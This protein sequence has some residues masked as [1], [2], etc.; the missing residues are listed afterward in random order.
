MASRTSKT[1]T[2]K[3]NLEVKLSDPVT[4]NNFANYLLSMTGKDITFDF[5]MNSMGNFDG[6]VIANPYDLLIVPKNTFAYKTA[7]GKSATNKNEFTTTVGLYIFNLLLSSVD[8]T[9]IVGYIN[10]NINGKSY[11]AIDQQMFYAIIEDRINIQ[12]YKEWQMI[13][14][15][16]MPLQ[17]ILSTCHTEKML[18][19]GKAI[20]KRKAELIK[21]NQEA[22]DAGDPKVIEDIEKELLELAKEYIGDDPGLDSLN[23]GAGASFGNQFKNMYIIKGA[24]ANPDPN[25]QKKYTIITSSFI[26]GI[27]SDEYTVLGQS[28]VN[29]SYSR[30][31][32]TSVGGY[33]EKL[34]IN[35][36]QHVKLDPVGSDCGTKRFIIIELTE[37]NL[38]D[39]IYSY[40]I[41]NDGGLELITSQNYKKF[42]G[43]KTKIRFSS[44]C[45]S[46][47][48]ICNICAGKLIYTASSENIAIATGQI[49][50]KIKTIAMKSFH[51][52]TVTNYTI[53][54]LNA[55]FYP[56]N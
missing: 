44:M 53:T 41:K 20:A 7:D 19:V 56:D 52:S 1:W 42:I 4:K 36:L 51:D 15:W 33:W 29:G 9:H 26:E 8:M 13:L 28:G 14:Q 22:I 35:S 24:V 38:N 49:P 21:Q 2:K 40:A 10:K 37:D 11:G 16:L 18:T 43:K 30:G 23:S 31:K 6:D 27:K 32:K 17:D 46:R 5:M 25:A 47:T 12:Q 48:G 54:D 55:L 34:F 45:E 39:Y 3:D 50:D